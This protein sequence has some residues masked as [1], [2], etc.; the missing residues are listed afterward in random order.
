[1]ISI[2]S[3]GRSVIFIS[4]SSGPFSWP[5]TIAQIL[6]VTDEFC[7]LRRSVFSDLKQ[8]DP[9]ACPIPST[10]YFLNQSF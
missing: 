3:A 6:E 2:I 7:P 9:A 1:M 10:E 4:P 8:Q 5:G